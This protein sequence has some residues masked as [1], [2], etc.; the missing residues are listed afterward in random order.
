MGP[1]PKLQDIPFSSSPDSRQISA[2]SAAAVELHMRLEELQA[3]ARRMG[4]GIGLKHLGPKGF[5]PICNL[6]HPDFD[7]FQSRKS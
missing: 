2:H 3:T 5:G 6:R 4:R 7:Y 1:S